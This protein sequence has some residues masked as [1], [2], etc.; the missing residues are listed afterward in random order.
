MAPTRLKYDATPLRLAAS[1]GSKG[2]Q[3]A[4]SPTERETLDEAFAVLMSCSDIL[5]D[6]D[7][8]DF[9]PPRFWPYTLEAAMRM[10]VASFRAFITDWDA[11]FSKEPENIPDNVPADF[12]RVVLGTVGTWLTDPSSYDRTD[13]DA[14]YEFIKDDVC[15]DGYL[16]NDFPKTPPIIG[17]FCI[18]SLYL[19][20]VENC[21]P[22]VGLMID[23]LNPSGIYCA[24]MPDAIGQWLYAGFSE[25]R[26]RESIRDDVIPWC[27]GDA[28]PLA[29]ATEQIGEPERRRFL[30]LTR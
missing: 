7:R 12:P 28:D 22:D 10:A 15:V 8:F 2:A 13:I 9:G 27:L 24:R 5:I 17:T 25:S 21:Q 16:T 4:L 30:R 11:A 18:G 20:D 1:L 23:E 26:I 3:E 19:I 14:L 29:K 6:D